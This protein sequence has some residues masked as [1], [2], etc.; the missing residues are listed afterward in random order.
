MHP[1][2]LRVDPVG[3][4]ERKDVVDRRRPDPRPLRRIHPVGEVKDVEAADEPFDRTSSEPAPAGPPV[5]RP[6]RDDD[7]PALDRN[8]VERL[9]DPALSGRRHERER[10]DVVLAAGF[11]QA[12]K[13]PEDVVADPG[14]RQRERRDVD[15][16]AQESV[17]VGQQDVEGC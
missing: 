15:D 1:K 11:G 8:A 16:D 13:H 12:S 10:D 2:G 14:S 3:M 17:L 9:L 4:A 5:M 7:E 6:R